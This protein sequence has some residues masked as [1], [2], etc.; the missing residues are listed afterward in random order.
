MPVLASIPVDHPSDAGTG[1]GCSRNTSQ[2]W[3]TRWQLRTALR[4][5]GQAEIVSPRQRATAC[6]VA[7]A[8][9]VFRP[10]G[11]ALG[12]QLAVFAASLGIP[13][14]LVIGPQQD[15]KAHGGAARRVRRAAAVTAAI[16]AAAV[17][18][19]DH[20]DLAGGRREP[21]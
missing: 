20:D 8:L 15:V 13:T 19:A 12:P 11:A 21:G 4:Y 5:L 7:V 6:S 2:A 17:I 9:A 3:S 10:G 16:R 1:P 18:V 14:A